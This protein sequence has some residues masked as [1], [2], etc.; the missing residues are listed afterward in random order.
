LLFVIGLLGA[1][2]AGCNGSSSSEKPAEV[3]PTASPAA[4]P[5]PPVSAADGFDGSCKGPECVAKCD[6]LGRRRDCYEAGDAYRRGKDDLAA[7][8]PSAVKY[9]EKACAKK[10]SE[11]CY[12]LGHLYSVADK[13]VAQDVAKAITYQTSACEYGRGQACDELAKRAESGDGMPKDH[14]KAIGLLARG[15]AAKDYQEW[16]C[17]AFKKAVDAKDPD[18]MKAVAAWKTSCAAKEKAGCDGLERADL[19]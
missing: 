7:N 15:C 16:T 10:N 2:S 1:V 18:A 6:R 5:E 8:V 17:R 3:K 9:L 19:K 12:D 13:G 11:G 4:A 14:A